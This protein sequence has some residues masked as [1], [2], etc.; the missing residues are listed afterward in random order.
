MELEDEIVANRRKRL[1]QWI[2]DH[3][4]G[5]QASFVAATEINQGELSSLLRDKSFGEK[6][7]RAIERAAGMPALYLD[8]TDRVVGMPIAQYAEGDDGK[9]ITV[10]K[11]ANEVG[12][13]LRDELEFD[14]IDGRHAFRRDWITK[15]GWS[16]GDLRVVD[17]SGD[18]QKPYINDGDVVLV[19]INPR[20]RKI[21]DGEY[22]VLRI[23]HGLT[24]KKCFRQF[25]GKVRLESLNAP[26]DYLTPDNPGEVLGM[27]VHRAG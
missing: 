3:Y 24:I 18:S 11:L 21:I 15:K 6:R 17:A 12:L 26:T 9:F 8:G 10:Q 14:E 25:D 2:N 7:A 20:H 4:D 27:V 19:N 1:R 13:G 22:Y 16:I 23:D 5:V